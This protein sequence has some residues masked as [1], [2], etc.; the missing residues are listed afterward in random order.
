MSNTISLKYLP[1]LT[2]DVE[3]RL[4]DYV[5]DCVVNA[6]EFS[7]GNLSPRRCCPPS[8]L[9]EFAL[10]KQFVTRMIKKSGVSVHGI[11]VALVYIDRLKQ[12]ELL[13]NYKEAVYERL[14]IGA[15]ILALKHLGHGNLT[16][17][18]DWA[19]MSLLFNP[20]QIEELELEFIVALDHKLGV[21]GFELLLHRLVILQITSS[22]TTP[23]I[24]PL[25]DNSCPM[26]ANFCPPHHCY[27]NS[28]RT[29]PVLQG[30]ADVN[31]PLPKT[32]RRNYLRSLF[33]L[34]STSSFN[35]A[36]CTPLRAH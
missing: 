7:K 13:T 8:Q 14:F 35:Y 16:T 17:S 30:C 26:R 15:L 11:A 12:E 20:V 25:H 19:R 4:H 2:H 21:A 22:L 6:V 1:N 33:S 23:R 5:V 9:P 3:S 28:S 34:G 32:P 18:H 36:H 31:K 10:F 29:L 24:C 27:T